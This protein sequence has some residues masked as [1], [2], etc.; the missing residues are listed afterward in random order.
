MEVVMDVY[1]LGGLSWRLSSQTLHI[2]YA[3][4]MAMLVF[5]ARIFFQQLPPGMLKRTR[6]CLPYTALRN[7]DGPAK[8][9][10][11]A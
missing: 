9:Y 4:V 5:A 6:T 11:V 8:R 3:K 2:P 1:K 10:S 7:L